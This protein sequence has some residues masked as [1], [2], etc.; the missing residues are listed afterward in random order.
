[1]KQI[2][3]YNS[4]INLDKLDNLSNHTELDNT[5]DIFNAV[6]LQVNNYLLKFF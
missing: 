2:D 1:M 5:L 4:M 3:I 6:F